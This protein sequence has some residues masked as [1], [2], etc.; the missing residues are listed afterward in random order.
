MTYQDNIIKFTEKAIEDIFRTSRAMPEDK[1]DWSPLG[2]GRSALD[3]LRECAQA[4]TWFTGIIKER[5]FPDISPEDMAKGREAR[6]QW[7]TI[8]DC[9]K[10][11]QANATA[12]Y[13]AMREVPEAD[14]TQVIHLPFGGGMDMP[15]MVVMAMNYWNTVY[16]LGQVNYI[17]TLYG[18]KD[19]H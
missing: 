19:M 16:H 4:P 8:D 1:I 7:K 12:M 17:Q 5:K 10:V 9:E 11:C 3:I 18:D 14:F 2:E 6:E 15:L 13:A